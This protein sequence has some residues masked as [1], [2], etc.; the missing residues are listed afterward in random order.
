MNSIPNYIPEIE[1]VM[2]SKKVYPL[3]DLFLKL[4]KDYPEIGSMRN[5][6]NDIEKYLNNFSINQ[7]NLIINRNCLAND[8][9]K[10]LNR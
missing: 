9:L 3:K 2:T 7:N 10:V 8:L 1:K 6:K 4:R 5:L